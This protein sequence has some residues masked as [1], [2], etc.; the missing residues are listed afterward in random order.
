MYRPIYREEVYD[1]PG[2]ARD[3]QLDRRLGDGQ[4]RRAEVIAQKVKPALDPPNERGDLVIW[5]Q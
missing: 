5:D 2:G 4:P 3:E 1:E